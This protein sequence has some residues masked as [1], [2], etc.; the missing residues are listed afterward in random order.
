MLYEILSKNKYM[1][2][3]QETPRQINRVEKVEINVGSSLNLWLV[4]GV[5]VLGGIL[6]SKINELS[7]RVRDLEKKLNTKTY[8]H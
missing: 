7:E 8:A 4:L 3:N 2:P 6:W 5:V 1:S